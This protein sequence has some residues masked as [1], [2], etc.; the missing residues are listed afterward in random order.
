MHP[1]FILLCCDMLLRVPNKINPRRN[2][3][4]H[5][6]IKLTNTHTHTHTHTHT[7][8]PRKAAREK[9]KITYK[10]IPIRLSANCS[11]ETLQARKERQDIFKVMKEEKPTTKIIL[12][13]KGLTQ[14]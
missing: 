3:S 5:I 9:Q 12:P 14:I 10:E 4:R 8:T 6:L 1:I 13:S 7:Q 11:G 2:T